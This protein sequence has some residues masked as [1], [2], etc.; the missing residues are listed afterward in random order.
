M[1][2]FL[3]DTPMRVL[4]LKGPSKNHDSKPAAPLCI[5]LH[6]FFLDCSSGAIQLLLPNKP[7]S[8]HW[9]ASTAAYVMINLVSDR[10]GSR[11]WNWFDLFH[12]FSFLKLQNIFRK[13]SSHT[14]VFEVCMS[15]TLPSTRIV[16]T[17]PAWNW[18]QIL[19]AISGRW[20]LGWPAT[21]AAFIT[22]PD[23]QLHKLPGPG[24]PFP[25]NLSVSSDAMYLLCMSPGFCYLYHFGWAMLGM[26]PWLLG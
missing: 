5:G 22:C 26:L 4:H 14:S 21:Q 3:K 17:K 8:P 16:I 20:F 19:T 2:V 12:P 25:T 18:S 9:F 23:R 13:E 11:F 24:S 10:Y 7:D 1:W 6:R 15:V